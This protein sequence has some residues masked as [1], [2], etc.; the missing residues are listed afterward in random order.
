MKLLNIAF[1]L[2]MLALS[3]SLLSACQSASASI[4]LSPTDILFESDQGSISEMESPIVTPFPLRPAYEPGEIVDY[5]AQSGDT[6]PTLAARFNT[7]V[8]EI[9]AVNTFIPPTATTM[10]PGMPMNIPIYYRP[11]WG[12]PYKIIPDSLFVN[13]PSQKRFDTSNFVAN[14]QGWLSNYTEYAAGDKRTGAE[15][16]DLIAQ[17]YSISPRLLLALLEYQSGALSEPEPSGVSEA[18]I[19]GYKDTRRRGLYLQ[20]IWAANTLNNGYYG[21]RNGILT[22]FEHLDGRLERSDPWQNAA[23]VALQY[24]FSRLLPLESYANAVSQ[25]GLANTYHTMFGNPWT[26][27]DAHIP[28]S[29]V[30][31]EFTLPF[32]PGVAWALTGGPHTAWG[33]GEP[34][35]A[36]DFA[37]GALESGCVPTNEW[38]T[39]VASGTVVRSETGTVVLDLDGDGDEHTGWVIFYFHVGTEG[40]AQVGQVLQVGDRIGH[41]S[42]EGGRTTGTH[43]HIA[44]KYN[45][46]WISAASPVGFTM[47]GWVAYDGDIPY[48][49]GLIRNSLRIQASESSDRESHIW[50]GEQ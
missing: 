30:Q 35:A 19:L 22:S 2:I 9:L 50:A 18:Y 11:F 37:P 44:R 14:Y 24:Y 13:G 43:V 25:D 45:G 1:I 32:N 3:S 12:T 48:K 47:E 42:C 27:V 49:G 36:L 17:N 16:V 10:P 6:L 40:R 41:P 5:I 26:A 7:T 4:P 20:L 33:E 23:T 29:L 28:G 39:A 34:F 21:W 38:T 31:P 46:E 15:L 8:E